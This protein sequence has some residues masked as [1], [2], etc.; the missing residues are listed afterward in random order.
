MTFAV[1]GHVYGNPDTYTSSL[2]P[3]FL[4]KLKEDHHTH[5]FDFLFLTGDVVHDTAASTW[6]YV[7]GQ[8]DSLNLKWLVAPGN[9]DPGGG[10]IQT[11]SDIKTGSDATPG[12]EVIK[13][14]NNYYL[15]LNTSN[16]GWTIGKPEWL[17][18]SAFFQDEDSIQNIFVF[19][20]QLW[21][22]RNAPAEFELDS[23]RPNSFEFYEGESDFWQDGFPWL[24]K[25][26]ADIW[27]FAGDLGADEKLESYYEDH[28]GQFHFYGSGMGGGKA[29][30]YLLVEVY[31]NGKVDIEKVNF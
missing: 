9:H 26:G 28:H 6:Q 15:V 25:T 17:A 14:A 19:T 27:F 18:L 29:D 13:D 12:M 11:S 5:Q 3:H 8:L 30:N 31:Q 16:P 10:K 2:Y 20:H 7:T 21:W 22:E 4:K 24:E 23:I 1:A